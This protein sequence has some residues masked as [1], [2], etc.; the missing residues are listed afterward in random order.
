MK[1]AIQVVDGDPVSRRPPTAENPVTWKIQSCSI[2]RK[3][4]VIPAMICGKY[5]VG[6]RRELSNI[7]E[8]LPEISTTATPGVIVFVVVVAV[9]SG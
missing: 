8:I 5:G 4:L 7:I 3:V 1:A 6:S 2:L 9:S